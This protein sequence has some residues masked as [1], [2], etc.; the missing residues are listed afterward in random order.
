MKH[1][2]LIAIGGTAICFVV[3]GLGRASDP[4]PEPPKVATTNDVRI[5][6][7][8]SWE[9][10]FFNNR[11]ATFLD[12]SL[13]V[14]GGAAADATACGDLRVDSIQDE[15][16]KSLDVMYVLGMHLLHHQ[17]SVE[18]PKG[19]VRISL[20][21]H[22]PPPLKK[23]RELRG[24]FA[25]QT[26]GQ[27]QVVVVKDAL[28]QTGNLINDATLT[29]LGVKVRMTRKTRPPSANTK[30]KIT[31][32]VSQIDGRAVGTIRWSDFPPP[33]DDLELEATSSDNPIIHVEIIDADGK[34]IAPSGSSVDCDNSVKKAK[35]GFDEKLP[36]GTQLRLTIHRGAKTIRVPF[37]LKD[38]E[39]PPRKEPV[40]NS[41]P[42]LTPLPSDD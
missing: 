38:V 12:V 33:A 31:T 36:D 23:L 37:A 10:G 22:N 6:T 32:T 17:K 4:A 39:I 20:D 3:A 42:T 40:G 11:P 35:F 21:L 24:S 15:S 18:H 26:G 25:L 2:V 1:V 41:A 19:G 5:R 27:L 29:S 30:P 8:V 28:R 7:D 16:G 14:Q 9:N 13:I 34:P